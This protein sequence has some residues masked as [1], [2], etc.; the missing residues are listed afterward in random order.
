MIDDDFGSEEGFRNTLDIEG[1]L[2]RQMNRMAIY[3]DKDLKQYCSSVETF[4]LM[5]P[6][7]I[8]EKAILK[9]IEL[10]LTRG[11]YLSV[12][13]EKLVKYDDLSIFVNEQLEKSKMIWKAKKTKVFE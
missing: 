9:I 2:L 10:G 7:K 1:L 13:E 6:K 4:I 3:R 12:N 8:R 5:C 11:K